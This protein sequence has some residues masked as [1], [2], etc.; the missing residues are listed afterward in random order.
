MS[1]KELLAREIASLPDELT[2]EEAVERLYLLYRIKRQISPQTLPP[3]RPRDPRLEERLRAA[4]ELRRLQLPVEDVATL[5]RQSV[6]AP[7]DL[8]P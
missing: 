1:V 4:E 5:K 7:D 2:M 3:S 6:P 8:L